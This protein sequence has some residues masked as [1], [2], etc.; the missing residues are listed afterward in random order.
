MPWFGIEFFKLKIRPFLSILIDKIE[1]AYSISEQL[2]GFTSIDP[3]TFPK[4]A[5]D[6]TDSGEEE[7]YSSLIFIAEK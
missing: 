3:A 7:S 4:E 2:K 6:L 1:E 5:N